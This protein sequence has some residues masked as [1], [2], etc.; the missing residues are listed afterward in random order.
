MANNSNN[1]GSNR[2]EVP[3]AK[4]AMDRFKMEVASELGVD[5]KKGYNGDIT[6]KEAGSVGGEMVR[7]MIKR[8][9]QEMA[10]TGS[11]QE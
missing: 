4:D 1:S 10:G 2:V 7:K 6:A 11:G 5:L 8:Q 9:E 3:Q